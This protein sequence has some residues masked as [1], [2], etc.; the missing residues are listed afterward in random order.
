MRRRY[1]TGPITPGVFEFERS[2]WSIGALYSLNVIA[3]P[4]CDKFSASSDF[5][6]KLDVMSSKPCC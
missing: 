5:D 3:V 6:E 1:W 4:S 2:S